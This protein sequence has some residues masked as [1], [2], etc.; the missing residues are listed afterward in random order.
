M[1]KSITFLH[2]A[3]YFK[4]VLKVK[5]YQEGSA[6]Y[7]L[8]ECLRNSGTNKLTSLNSKPGSP[9][10]HELEGTSLLT[11]SCSNP[12]DHELKFQ[13]SSGLS[14]SRFGRYCGGGRKYSHSFSFYLIL[15][16]QASFSFLCHGIK[17][18]LASFCVFVTFENRIEMSIVVTPES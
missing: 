9:I 16:Q 1:N 10:L 6:I 13:F 18:R 11:V 12:R 4:L 2:R 7:M 8:V 15:F 3:F 14:M 17:S 5:S